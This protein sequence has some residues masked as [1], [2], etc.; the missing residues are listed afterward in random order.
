MC[1]SVTQCPL[2]HSDCEHVGFWSQKF[3]MPFAVCA[4]LC[5]AVCCPMDCSLPGSSGCEIVQAIR[6]EWEAI[7]SS[8]RSSW[9]RD[10]ICISCVSCMASGLF[11]SLSH[12]RSPW[13][14]EGPAQERLLMVI[15]FLS[16][17]EKIFFHWNIIIFW[18]LSMFLFANN[19]VDQ[20][21]GL[22]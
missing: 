18:N 6:L 10:R 20:E 12:L 17:E 5:P 2:G 16:E 19:S 7:S 15:Y 11:L 4:Q 9:P 1:D 13:Y 22:I 21:I 14:V 3:V 8:R